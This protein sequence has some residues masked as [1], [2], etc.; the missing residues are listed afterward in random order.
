MNHNYVVV[1]TWLTK[2]F[3]V[4]LNFIVFNFSLVK[5]A[6]VYSGTVT[7]GF[8]LWG[9]PHKKKMNNVRIE[10]MHLLPWR[11]FGK[12]NGDEEMGLE[13]DNLSESETHYNPRGSMY[14]YFQFH[15]HGIDAQF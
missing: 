6:F 4:I 9:V 1:D 8:E 5:V 12:E 15:M 2:Y 11:R 13:D 10:Y 7:A 3:C 14:R